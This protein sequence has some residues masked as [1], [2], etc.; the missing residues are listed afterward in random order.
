MDNLGRD[1]E[2][3]YLILAVCVGLAAFAAGCALG[4]WLWGRG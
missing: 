2:I 1:I 3:V 4:W